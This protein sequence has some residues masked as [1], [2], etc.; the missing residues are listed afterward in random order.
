M[1]FQVS[2][3]KPERMKFKKV[4]TSLIYL[5]KEHAE[6]SETLMLIEVRWLYIDNKK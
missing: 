6:Q 2:E 4:I 3:H 5:I 1:L